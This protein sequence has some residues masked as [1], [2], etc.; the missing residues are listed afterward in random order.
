MAKQK[1]TPSADLDETA[2]LPIIPAGA[3]VAVNE[4]PL[5]AT[6]AYNAPTLMR[7]L[8]V[9]DDTREQRIAQRDAEIGA[10]R[11]DLASVTESRGQLEH[12]LGNLTSNL[13]ELEQ[14]LNTKSEQLSMFEREVGQRDRRIAELEARTA[15]VDG[16]LA[17]TSSERD[18]LRA[19]R[20]NPHAS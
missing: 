16:E 17:A 13:R 1:E 5:S 8:P 7:A 11:S 20:P 10:L 15:T 3:G 4:D 19:G 14:L 12:N 18:S 2:E 6:D 9:A